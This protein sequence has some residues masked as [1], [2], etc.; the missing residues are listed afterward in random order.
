MTEL[1]AEGLRY[2]CPVALPS[3]V[4]GMADTLDLA[5]IGGPYAG[6]RSRG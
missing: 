4:Q 2:P 3:I 1:N 6:R 5:L